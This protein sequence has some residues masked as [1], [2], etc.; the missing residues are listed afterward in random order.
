V[1]DS[2]EVFNNPTRNHANNAM[3]SPVDYETEQKKIIEAAV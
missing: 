3:L 1:F 2:I